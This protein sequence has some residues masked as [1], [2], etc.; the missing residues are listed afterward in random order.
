MVCEPAGKGKGFRAKGSMIPVEAC[1]FGLRIMFKLLG[2]NVIKGAK[3][4]I[5]CDSNF[6]VLSLNIADFKI[7]LDTLMHKLFK[8]TRAVG[9]LAH[10]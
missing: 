1:T 2:A 9:D 6:W 8:D 7:C 10:M 5:C 3:R 4:I